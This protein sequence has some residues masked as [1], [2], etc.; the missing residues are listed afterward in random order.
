MVID[1]LTHSKVKIF[2][3]RYFVSFGEHNEAMELF[4]LVFYSH[5]LGK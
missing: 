2:L 5:K 4:F 3:M 1:I